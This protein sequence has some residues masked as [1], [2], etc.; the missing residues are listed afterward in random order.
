[1][2]SRQSAEPALNLLFENKI[3][4]YNTPLRSIRVISAM[5]RYKEFLD[6]YVPEI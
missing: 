3:P 5:V 6:R 1:M 4:V 2:S